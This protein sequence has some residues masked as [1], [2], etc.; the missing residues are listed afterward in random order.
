VTELLGAAEQATPD[1]RERGDRD[2]RVLFGVHQRR[3]IRL[4]W[5]LWSGLHCDRGRRDAEQGWF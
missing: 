3:V 5:V 1:R 2:I 4:G